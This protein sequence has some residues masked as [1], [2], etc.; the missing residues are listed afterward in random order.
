M[1]SNIAMN[2]RVSTNAASAKGQRFNENS[3]KKLKSC[4]KLR[5]NSPVTILSATA[6]ILWISVDMAK[7]NEG[8]SAKKK[9]KMKFLKIYLKVIPR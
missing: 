7:K 1:D 9:M 5:S 8:M 4:T 6:P 3:E 2:R